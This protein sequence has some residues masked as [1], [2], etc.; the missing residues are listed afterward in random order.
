MATAFLPGQMMDV[1][2]LKCSR[3]TICKLHDVAHSAPPFT[4]VLWTSVLPLQY[5][6]EPLQQRLNGSQKPKTATVR[7]FLVLFHSSGLNIP[8]SAASP[9]PHLVLPYCFFSISHLCFFSY[10]VLICFY[11]FICLHHWIIS[12]ADLFLEI[13]VGFIIHLFKITVCS[14]GG[15]SLLHEL[16]K[17]F[18]Y[19]HSFFSTCSETLIFPY[20][21]I[22]WF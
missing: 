10:F 17:A 22:N 14:G 1:F 21:I 6:A 18:C 12:C 11:D 4:P 3:P 5:R 15:I 13:T 9:W 2:E 8:F 7:L 20:N 16:C 19:A